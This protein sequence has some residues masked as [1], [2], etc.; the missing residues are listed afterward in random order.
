MNN[1]GCFFQLMGRLPPERRK[2]LYHGVAHWPYPGPA[3]CYIGGCGGTPDF[4]ALTGGFDDLWVGAACERHAK[5]FAERYRLPFPG[6]QV[7]IGGD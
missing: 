4:T 5:K 2:R 6:P 7:I 1:V 3:K